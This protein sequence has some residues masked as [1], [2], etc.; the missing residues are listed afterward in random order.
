MCDGLEKMGELVVRVSKWRSR[1]RVCG[2][3]ERRGK[4][5]NIWSER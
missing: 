1:R 2:K 3:V 5:I 4:G